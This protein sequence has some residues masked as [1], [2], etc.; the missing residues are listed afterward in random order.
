M[1]G[2]RAAPPVSSALELAE[3]LQRWLKGMPILAR[4]VGQA[5]PRGMWCRR[6][7][8]LATVAASWCWPCG[9]IRRHHLEVARSRSENKKAEAVRELL[10][11]GLLG[12]ASVEIDPLGRNLPVQKLLD[13]TADGLGIWL[14]D[15]PEIVAKIQETIGGAYLSL[16]R[17]DRAELQLR[18]RSASTTSS[19]DP[20]I[21]TPCAPPICWPRSWTRPAAAPKPSG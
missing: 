1:P 8:A 21:R 16:G 18:T 12:Q 4:P 15:Q 20:D 14:E 2:E 6:N 5:D 17:Y 10:T 3:D 11:T 13:R 19:M 7:K 9:R